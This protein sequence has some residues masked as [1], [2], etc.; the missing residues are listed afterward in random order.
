MTRTTT[1]VTLAL[2]SSILTP[3]VV[4]ATG[5][6]QKSAMAEPKATMQTAAATTTPAPAAETPACTRKVKVV[7]G[8]FAEVHAAAC[9]TTAEVRR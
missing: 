7:Y 9:A 2:L 3:V 4:S 5:A 6:T 8:A 1:I